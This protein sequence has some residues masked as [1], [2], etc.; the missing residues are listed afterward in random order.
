MFR[1]VVP[2]FYGGYLLHIM[3]IMGDI[4]SLTNYWAI[5]GGD[6]KPKSWPRIMASMASIPEPR[7]NEKDTLALPTA[8]AVHSGFWLSMVITRG[9]YKAKPPSKAKG[10]QQGYPANR[11]HLG[12]ILP[13]VENDTYSIWH[14]IARTRRSMAYSGPLPYNSHTQCWQPNNKPTIWGWLKSHP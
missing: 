4:Q 9:H 1:K 10:W 7:Y 11:S 2:G 6:A 13:G 12:I 5:R 14:L 8:G 3:A